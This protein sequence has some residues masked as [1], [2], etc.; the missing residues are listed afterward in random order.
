MMEAR[1]ILATMAQRCTLSLESPEEIRPVQTVT[2]RPATP[3]RMRFH[4]RNPQ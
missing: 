3:V 2:L 1:L 4:R